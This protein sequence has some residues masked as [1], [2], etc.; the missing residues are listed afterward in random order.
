[1][2][3]TSK[4]ATSKVSEYLESLPGW[5]RAICAELRRIILSTD[6]SI[7]EEWKWG[8]S[9]SSNGL[10]CGWSAF[11]KHVKVT[12]FNGGGMSDKSGLFNHCLDNEFNRSIK[13]TSPDEIN[14][15]LLKAYIKESM[16]VNAAGFKRV[17]APRTDAV[18]AELTAALKKD[19][20]ALTFFEA[21]TPGYKRE[22]IEMVTSARQEKTRE[23]RIAKVVAACAEGRKPNDQY[24][25]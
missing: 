22:Y 17:V 16:A 23:A 9:Y 11:Q 4:A 5:S 6:P 24:K 7:T 20:K 12:F 15:K 3:T 13:F 10:V 18:P 14:E 2:P 25:K 21:L 1:M 8:P 19:K